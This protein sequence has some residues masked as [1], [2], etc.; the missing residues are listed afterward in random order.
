M[1]LLILTFALLAIL[2]GCKTPTYRVQVFQG[3]R[4]L[5]EFVHEGDLHHLAAGGWNG[6]NLQVPGGTFGRMTEAMVMASDGVIVA[7]RIHPEE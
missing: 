1:R 7:E 5:V 6:L 2:A 3:G 4:K